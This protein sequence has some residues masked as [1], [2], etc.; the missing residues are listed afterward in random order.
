MF[1][2]LKKA[3][4]LLAE[5]GKEAMEDSIDATKGAIDGAKAKI[6]G[7]EVINGGVKT[8][9]LSNA[10]LIKLQE[11]HSVELDDTETKDGYDTVIIK[12]AMES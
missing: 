4:S 12:I 3:G 7:I 1:D 9:I 8:I 5:A 2:K 6:N 11:N 10:E